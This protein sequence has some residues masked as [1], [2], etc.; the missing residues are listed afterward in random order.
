MVLCRRSSAGQ[1]LH[2]LALDRLDN[3]FAEAFLL[4]GST[5][6]CK[7]HWSTAAV[8]NDASIWPSIVD[9]PD[10]RIATVAECWSRRLVGRDQ[11]A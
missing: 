7:G 10:F 6:G 5:V 9:E 11:R 2:T 4:E 8:G 1:G 3:F